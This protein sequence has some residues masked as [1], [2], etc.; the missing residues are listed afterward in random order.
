MSTLAR[1]ALFGAIGTLLF[2]P[3]VVKRKHRHRHRHGSPVLVR[4][5]GSGGKKGRK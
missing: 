5:G 3:L 1:L 4:A 2:L